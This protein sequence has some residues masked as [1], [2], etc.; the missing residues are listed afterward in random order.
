MKRKFV[1]RSNWIRI[2]KSK[3]KTVKLENDEFNGYI[4]YTYIEK[5]NKRLEVKPKDKEYL[6][7]DD[8][9]TWVQIVPIDKHWTITIMYDENKKMIQWY[10]DITNMNGIDSDS[11]VFYDDMYLD[12]TVTNDGEIIL[13]D[14]QDI[15]DALD[16][17]VITSEQYKA[18]YKEASDMINFLRSKTPKYFERISNELLEYLKIK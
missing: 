11:R 2:S 18:A 6:I 8:G 13:L 9:Y 17:N 15:N 12:I 16:N 3:T 4:C 10:I 5:A 14:E 1:D 7:L